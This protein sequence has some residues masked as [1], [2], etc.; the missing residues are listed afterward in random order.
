MRIALLTTDNR[1]NLRQYG[2]KVPAFGSAPEAL[3]QG[4]AEIRD[5]E[6]HV[7][8]CAQQPMSSPCRLGDNIYFHG[9]HVRKYGWLRSGYQGCIRAVRR[10]LREI[11]PDIVHG[12]GTERDSALSAVFSGFPNVITIHGNMRSLAK[13]LGARIGSYYWWTAIL[14]GL[15]LK[16]SGG[17]FCNSEYTETLVRSHAR[18]TW[19]VSNALRKEFFGEISLRREK[20][21][22]ILLNVGT[23]LPHKRQLE[24]LRVADRLHK[25]GNRFEMWFVGPI[26][27]SEPYGAA[28]SSCI[29]SRTFAQHFSYYEVDKLRSCYDHVDALVHFP[30]EEAFGLV[31]A[32]ALARNLMLF[33]ARTG[34]IPDI[35]EGLTGPQLLPTNDWTALEDAIESWLKG[36]RVPVATSTTMQS[37]YHPTTI[38][39]RH[40]EIYQEL[41]QTSR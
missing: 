20:S 32:E 25:K 24:I 15:A 23:I 9:L 22:P 28:V 21:T 26:D 1:E 36:D 7:I 10:L 6:V 8:S 35:T 29:S 40:L 13:T 18:R 11:K 41:L 17:V 30:K 4:F 14:E 2:S 37:R 33:G 5:V 12:Q 16:K 34:G 27:V 31:V 39:R 38:A 3:L 19:R